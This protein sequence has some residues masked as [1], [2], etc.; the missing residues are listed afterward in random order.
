[1][2]TRL[3]P[4]LLAVT[5]L[6]LFTGCKKTYFGNEAIESLGQLQVAFVDAAW[7]GKFVPAG[8]QCA[9]FGG[10]NAMSPALRVGG[11]PAG[12]D[13]IIVEFNDRTYTPLSTNGGHGAIAVAVP[14]GATE[15]VV[16]S[17]AGETNDVPA[18]VTVIH[19]HRATWSV[20][21]PGA[22]L[23]PCSGGKG[24][25]YFAIVHAVNTTDKV[26]LAQARVALGTY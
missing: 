13:Q 8:M 12:A 11:I 19:G 10:K 18:G 2:R 15:V 24:N 3:F 7:D 14:A 21:K 23:P 17:V 22:Y 9:Q 6:L 16:P 25:T 5:A 4:L 26:V 20:L 1:M